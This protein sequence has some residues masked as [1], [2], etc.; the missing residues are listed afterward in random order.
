MEDLGH[1]L[2]GLLA[3][4][5]GFREAWALVRLEQLWPGIA[6]QELSAYVRVADLRRGVLI[7][8]VSNPAWAT[9]MH[10]YKPTILEKIKQ[11]LPDAEVTELKTRVAEPRPTGTAQVTEKPVKPEEDLDA[12]I[13]PLLDGLD[14]AGETYREMQTVLR[15]YLRWQDQDERPT[16]PICGQRYQGTD[17]IC[18]DCKNENLDAKD[19][20]IAE[21][22]EEAPW[23]RYTDILQDLPHIAEDHYHH[24][25]EKMTARKHD[26]VQALYFEYTKTPTKKL[27]TVLEKA[28]LALVML[29]T[30]L[31][32]SQITE[33]IIKQYVP[34]RVYTTLYK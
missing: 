26:K 22:L 9:Q 28:V 27:K 11:Q 18:I 8:E 34:S 6:G 20:E 4:Q 2:Q 16:C 13:A 17:S 25:K 7:L 12:R 32:P 29:K 19:R 5:P 15:K 31:P 14:P 21:Y 10:F 30:G 3:T 24:V 23:S 33:L 1:I